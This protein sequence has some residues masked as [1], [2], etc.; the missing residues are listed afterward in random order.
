MTSVQI[1]SVFALATAYMAGVGPFYQALAE[2]QA[3]AASVFRVINEVKL[4]YS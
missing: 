2:A 4:D 1:V 3:A